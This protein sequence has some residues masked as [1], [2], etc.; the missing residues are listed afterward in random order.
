MIV[1]HRTTGLELPK[2][3][4]LVATI[5]NFDGLH[6]GHQAIMRTIRGLAD[7]CG[8]LATVLTFHPHPLR[9]VAPERAPRLL[10]TGDQKTALLESMGMDAVVVIPFDRTLATMPA[11]EFA[12]ELLGQRIG[13]SR[14]LIG[15]DF[16]FGRGRVGNVELLQQIGAEVGYEA[17]AVEPVMLG[18]ERVS[19]S[20]VRRELEQGHVEQATRLLGRPFSLLGTVVHGEGRGRKVLLPTANLAPEN[21]FVPERGVYITRMRFDGAEHYGVTNVGLRP[22]FGGKRI[23]IET[24]LSGFAGDAYGRRA[25]LE[26]HARIRPEIKFDTPQDLMAQIWKDIEVFEAWCKERG[27]VVDLDRP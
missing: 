4:P 5:G 27:V 17:Q 14:I 19:A 3:K 16:R 9:V 25:E 1:A 24:F 12:R 6:V 8:G 18:T 10:L 23:T 11:E 15:P 20:R 26:F 2:D 13:V 21:E 22:T 7:E